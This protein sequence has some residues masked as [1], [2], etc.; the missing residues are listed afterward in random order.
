MT[1]RKHQILLL[2]AAAL[3]GF[4]LAAGPAL[5]EMSDDRAPPP[6]PAG[7]KKKNDDKKK[8]P[9]TGQQKKE[10]QSQFLDGYKPAAA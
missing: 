9:T 10:K 3:L 2:G 8:P 5:A 7:D 4:A 6:A 1:S